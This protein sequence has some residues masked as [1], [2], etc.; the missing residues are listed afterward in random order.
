VI[1][2]SKASMINEL[3]EKLSSNS[4][5]ESSLCAM[6]II[7]FLLN[8]HREYSELVAIV[9]SEDSISKIG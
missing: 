2:K 8:D 9:M 7:Q 3:I 6:E 5:E 4:C 1:K